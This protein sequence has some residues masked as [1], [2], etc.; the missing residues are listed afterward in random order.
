[1]RSKSLG[2]LKEKVT[3]GFRSGAESNPKM[4]VLRSIPI[5]SVKDF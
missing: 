1:M 3:K 4:R 5:L 2:V